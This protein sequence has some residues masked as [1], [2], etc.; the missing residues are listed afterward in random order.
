[1]NSTRTGAVASAAALVLAASAWTAY[2]Y[3]SPTGR[4]EFEAVT[5]HNPDDDQEVATAARD[6]FRATVERRAGARTIRNVPSEIY[7]VRVTHAY[8]GNLTGTVSVTQLPEDPP[9][10]TG[11]AYIFPTVP[12]DDT[13]AEHA[14][15]AETVPRPADHLGRPATTST[16]PAHGT[17]DEHWTWVTTHPAA[18]INTYR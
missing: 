1:M 9:L 17:V 11:H 18:G 12:W 8:K 15:L 7:E 14:V 16:G 5:L 3:L 13:G 10:H 4:T 6:V 2:S